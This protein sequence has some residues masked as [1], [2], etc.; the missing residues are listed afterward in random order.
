MRRL[1]LFCFLIGSL[2]VFAQATEKYQSVLS[3]FYHAEEL[4]E[5]EQYSAARKEFRLFVDQYQGS[6]NDPYYMKALY[7]EGLSALRLYNN[8]A[9]DLLQKFNKDYP[10]SVYKSAIMLE[11]GRYYY[12]KKDYKK[13][14]EWLAQ[15]SSHDVEPEDKQEYYFKLGYSYYEEQQFPEAKNAFYEIK[16]STSQYGTPALY[17]YSHLSYKDGSYTIALQGFQKLLPDPRFRTV[18]PYYITQIHYLQ[19]NYQEVTNF[20]PQ[21]VDSLKPADQI[22]LNHLIGDSYYKLGKYDESV[23]YLEAYNLKAATTRDDD[24]ALGYAYFRSGAYDKSIKY[25]DKVSR[26]KDTL[27]QISLYH[28]AEAYL[29]LD[30]PAYAR[31][32]FGAAAEINKDL[33]IQ[34]DALY[35]YAVLSY[36]ID[37]NPYD[38]AVTALEE[39]LQRYPDSPRKNVVYQYLVNVYASTRNYEK[40]LESLDKLDNKDIKLKTAYQIIA[41]N[42]GVELYQNGQYSK[43]ID[44]FALVKK[45]PVSQEVSAKAVFWTAD[46]EFMQKDFRKSIDDYSVFTTM[47]QS[48]ATGLK[49]DAYYNMGYACLESKDLE[50]MKQSFTNFLQQPDLTKKKKADAEMRLGDVYYL[51]NDNAAAIQHYEAAFA[52]KSGAEDQALYYLSRLYGLSGNRDKKIAAL[53][54]I[55]NNYPKSQYVQSSIYAAGESFF[56]AKNLDK[57]QRYFEQLVKDYPNSLLVKDA[58]HYIGDINFQKG[59]FSQAEAYYKRV[60]SDYGGNDRETCRREVEALADIYTAQKNL[61]KVEALATQYPCA[62]SIRFQVEDKFYTQAIKP[63]EDSNFVQ[64]LEEFNRYL[65]KYPEGKYTTEIMAYKADALY[66]LKREEEAVAI[67]KVLLEKPDNDFTEVAAQRTSK[68]LYNSK[69]YEEALPVYSRL[70][71]VARDPENIYSANLGLMRCHFIVENYSNVVEYAQKVLQTAKINNTVKLEGEFA[72]GI[73]LARTD[74]YAESLA[75]LEYVIKNTTTEFASEARFTIAESYYKQN[76]NPKAEEQIRLLLKMKPSY[77][78]WIAKAL[79][80]QT[81]ILVAKNDLFQAEQTINSVIENYKVTDDGILNEAGELYDEIMQL[82]NEP[83]TIE[84]RG[85]TEI[86]LNPGEGQK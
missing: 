37:L 76:D 32:A 52:L 62:D 50:G 74:R 21:F 57:A 49:D 78:F 14:V 53:T 71:K 38:E 35:N 15:L 59:N 84:E 63:Y 70:E 61:E 34:E 5:K 73:S 30:Q 51:K 26:I 2:Q 65:A 17:Y 66:R 79:I 43:A 7:Y 41:F 48:G 72:L 28:A 81:R 18:V 64:S 36:K 31:K 23:P 45:Y 3:G 69:K 75:H 83:K 16:D 22:E 54:D 46:T 29:K 86:D 8:D 19:G 47:S 42:R 85:E 55:I 58:L 82:K 27:G 44:A 6:K 77:N 10:E 9:V 11:I 4:F 20:A 67:Y 60:L 1:I 13:S 39:Y 24:Y 68:F 12:Q 33:M 80:L 25:F 40:A 56:Q